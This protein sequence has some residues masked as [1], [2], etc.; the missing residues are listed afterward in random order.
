MDDAT[1]I[2]GS[3][4][5]IHRPARFDLK[6]LPL[7]IGLTGLTGRPPVAAARP[8][9]A[10]VVVVAVV[11]VVVASLGTLPVRWVAPFA[12]GRVGRCGSGGALD[13]A[14]HDNARGHVSREG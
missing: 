6:V 4:A 14:A 9:P 10:R 3:S 13:Q 8:L 2:L 12:R 11:S 7:A 5:W 1:E